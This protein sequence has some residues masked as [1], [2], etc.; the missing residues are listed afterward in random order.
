[1]KL[2]L[3]QMYYMAGAIATSTMIAAPASAETLSSMMKRLTDQM[4]SVAAFAVA[5][6]FVLGVILGGLSILKFKEN[7]DNPNQSKMGKPI[8]YLVASAALIGIPSYLA[9]FTNT[10]TGEGHDSS[11]S[12]GETYKE[13]R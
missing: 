5:V 7:A 11:D 12:S 10:L 9:I 4:S 6:M 8:G 3:K 1:M 13:I 2:N